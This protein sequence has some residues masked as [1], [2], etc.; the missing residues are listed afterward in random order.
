MT[1]PIILS[2][3]SSPH[4]RGVKLLLFFCFFLTVELVP[5]T[6]L[7]DETLFQSMHLARNNSLVLQEQE[8][9]IRSAEEDVSIARSALLPDVYLDASVGAFSREDGV[10]SDVNTQVET[11]A[12]TNF[13]L[14][15]SHTLWDG[16]ARQRDISGKLA[17]ID[18]EENRL[19]YLE[20]QV[21]MNVIKAHFNLR[22]ATSLLSLIDRSLAFAEKH[23]A[24]EVKRFGLGEATQTDLSLAKAYLAL[25]ESKHNSARTRLSNSQAR[26]EKFVGSQPYEN[27]GKLTL[28][29]RFPESMKEAIQIA[30]KEHPLLKASAK[31]IVEAEH[32]V[33]HERAAGLPKVFLDGSV[34]YGARPEDRYEN[35]STIGLRVRVPLFNSG[36]INSRIAKRQEDEYRRRLKFDRYAEEVFESVRIVFEALKSA[37]AEV[38]ISE[39]AAK[40]ASHALHSSEAERDHDLNSTPDLFD[41]HLKMVEAEMNALAA[42]R[43][44][45]IHRYALLFAVG[46]L[47]VPVETNKGELDTGRIDFPYVAAEQHAGATQKRADH[48]HGLRRMDGGDLKGLSAGMELRKRTQR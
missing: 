8:S 1:W 37:R 23:V 33:E 38:Q 3:K 43:N 48:W 18:A 36:V 17:R 32:L 44:L 40:Q 30:Q 41:A 35:L 19:L 16:S 6:S 47:V 24:L 27:F 25:L 34:S 26:Y 31:D 4:R 7:G 39:W 2:G 21:L 45:A 10:L 14:T 42:K 12:Y 13:R 20:Q 22:H 28:D 9:R 5:S 46:R 15:L 29:T 11:D